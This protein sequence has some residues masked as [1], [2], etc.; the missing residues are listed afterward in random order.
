MHLLEAER[1]AAWKQ[2]FW[3][4]DLHLFVYIQFTIYAMYCISFHESARRPVLC[5][6]D[7]SNNDTTNLT[8][9]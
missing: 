1:N 6:V 8:L 2:T 3:Y 5:Y 4:S 9:T 7:Q